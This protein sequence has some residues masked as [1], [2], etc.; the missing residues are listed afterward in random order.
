MRYMISEEY[1]KRIEADMELS[2]TLDD[3]EEEI[4]SGEGP[5]N[6]NNS[7]SL[8]FLSMSPQTTERLLRYLHQGT[9]VEWA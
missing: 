8:F 9:E 7:N 2:D 4:N 1:N 5:G 6:E 3:E